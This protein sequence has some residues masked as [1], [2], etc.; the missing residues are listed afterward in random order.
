M[1]LYT[2]G[3]E[4][5]DSRRF[6][7][8]LKRHGV[9][10]VADVRKLPLSRKKGFSK[11]QLKELLNSNSIQYLNFQELGASKELRN[12]LCQSGNYKAFF[13]KFQNGLTSKK[14]AL[15]TLHSMVN[16]GKKVSLL[17]FERDPRQCHRKI[18]A[19][20]IKNLNGNGLK[21]QHIIPL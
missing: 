1:I 4:G 16:S 10:V 19:E 9:D 8:L 15:E 6:V 5:L 18:V 12:E 11:T 17:C 20:E 7:S 3:Y 21:L 13:K 14:E 2:L